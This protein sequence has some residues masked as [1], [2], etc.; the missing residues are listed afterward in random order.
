M[1]I[2]KVNLKGFK[3]FHDLEIRNVPPARLV[4][5]TGPNGSGKSSLFDAFQKWRD[6][7]GG[8]TGFAGADPYY[9]RAQ[10]QRANE[11][12]IEW[13][14]DAPRG[15]DESR[16]ALVIRTSY[17][18]EPDFK[19]E[20]LSKVGEAKNEH[21]FKRL[22][23]ADKAVS[24]NYQRIASSLIHFASSLEHETKTGKEMQNELLNDTRES[25]KRLFNEE[26]ELIDIG[27]PLEGGTFFFKKGKIN[28]YSYMN[29]SGG[30][31]AAFDLILDFALKRKYFP[32]A[33][34]CIDEPEA[35]MS[36]RLQA[37]LLE[38]LF[39][40]VGDENQLWI[41]TH[42]IGMMRAAQ[43]L[44]TKNSDEVAFLDF[45]N[46]DFDEPAIIEPISPSRRF[47][48]DVLHVALD[49]MA[50]LVAPECVV[51]CEGNPLESQSGKNAEHDARVF[52]EI[53]R[54]EPTDTAFLSGGNSRE[55][56]TDH[57]AIVAS[58]EKIVGGVET[59]RLIDRDDHAEED[60]KEFAKDGIRV[61]SRR[62]LE[63]YLFDDE[64]LEVLAQSVG[65]PEKIADVRAA[66][67]HE[68]QQSEGRGNR[69]D[70]LKKIKGP[71]V[72]QLKQILDIR[73]GGNAPDAF[74][75]HILAPQLRPGM[76]VYEELKD[77]IFGERV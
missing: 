57:R 31:K 73:Q 69:D 33:V 72:G 12:Q 51:L 2:S 24:Q 61:L 4:V 7:H 67:Q 54:E 10:G 17:R 68:I 46:Q 71:F 62:H 22:I 21:R 23:D 36:T 50:E 25:V 65:K 74:C 60:I 58:I 45:S 27:A 30:E 43:A 77:A 20:S 8:F 76:K 16:T 64:V 34:F 9:S 38:E 19:T 37:R 56:S 75:R 15:Q 47:W 28:R 39:A 52:E 11:P 6:Q 1:Q 49:D 40:L 13:H 29:L 55:V 63:S 3:R 26:L 42:S 53:F 5:L 59:I 48:R 32:K 66:K 18:H 14:G 35:H 70:D 44:F 41:A